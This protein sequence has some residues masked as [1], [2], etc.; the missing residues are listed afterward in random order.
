LQEW[1]GFEEMEKE[2]D[3]NEKVES[4]MNQGKKVEMQISMSSFS[5]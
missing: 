2:K 5:L 4:C 3:Y 1:V